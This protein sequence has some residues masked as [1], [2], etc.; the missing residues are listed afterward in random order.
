MKKPNFFKWLCAR[1]LRLAQYIGIWVG[2]FFVLFLIA[3]AIP[4]TS[5]VG[6]DGVKYMNESISVICMVV[7]LI[8]II[9]IT[10]IRKYSK[11][12]Y[13]SQTEAPL[14]KEQPLQSVEGIDVVEPEV[15]G[16]IDINS[17]HVSF[18]QEQESTVQKTDD[19]QNT[20]QQI[21]IE[22]VDWMDGHDFEEWCAD[23]LLKTGYDEAS[24]TK[25]SGDQGIDIVA[26]KD[27]IRYAIQCK[28]YSSNLGNKP[29]QEAYAGKEMYDCQVAAVMTNQHFTVGA[30]ELAE[31]TRVLLW[32]REKLKEMIADA[33]T[34][35]FDTKGI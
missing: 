22:D 27:G 18:V 19:S 23:L 13:E 33:N 6:E 31:K 9:I 32:D 21:T 1:I 12:M 24:V 5:H 10:L 2:G 35:T 26:V 16:K 29:V 7:P 20:H 34:L 8:I 3:S 14:N 30:K 17:L 15:I 28:C 11:Q 25:G 4:G